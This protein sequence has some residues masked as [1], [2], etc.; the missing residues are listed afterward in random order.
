MAGGVQDR[1]RERASAGPVR[2][3]HPLALAG[4]L[5]GFAAVACFALALAFGDRNADPSPWFWARYSRTCR[6]LQAG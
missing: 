1:A 3:P 4:V 2:R 5:S 6:Q